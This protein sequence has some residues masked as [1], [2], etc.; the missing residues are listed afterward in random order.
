MCVCTNLYLF[1]WAL[2]LT[3]NHIALIMDFVR[4]IY[5]LFT[6]TFDEYWSRGHDV[7]TLYVNW[8]CIIRY[9]IYI[10][11]VYWRNSLLLSCVLSTI[12]FPIMKI[13]SSEALLNYP[14]QYF[15]RIYPI[16]LY[17]ISFSGLEYFQLLHNNCCLNTWIITTFL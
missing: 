10:Y 14:S 1:F 16:T 3:L 7:W 12:I 17:I 5:I 2:C 11:V 4:N 9:R 13:L 15:S 8:S 6:I